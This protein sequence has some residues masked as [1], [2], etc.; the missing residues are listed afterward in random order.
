MGV[1]YCHRQKEIKF[2]I[3]I[4]GKRKIWFTISGL[5]VGL[6]I[7]FL[8]TWGLNFGIDFTG[9]SLL[10][11]N[12]Q[13]EV[14][15]TDDIIGI[16]KETKIIENASAQTV[17]EKGIVLR[18][19]TVSEEDHQKISDA[20]KKSYGDKVQESRFNSIGPTI[21]EGLKKKT[22]Q[23]LVLAIIGIVIYIAWA[24]RHVSKP[25]SSWK[26][27]IIANVAL[28]H[29]VIITLGAF[30]VL[31]K[32]YNMEINS[33]FIAAILTVLGYSVN[34]TIVVFDRIRENLKKYFSKSLEE[35]I[36]KSVSQSI[37]R[38]INTSFTVI[39]VL[40]AILLL[41]GTSVRDFALALIIGVTVGT[42]S[43]IFLASPLLIVMNNWSKGK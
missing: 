33:P 10:E 4:M 36:D 20:L 14:P 42:Y 38:S 19:K 13:E 21:G 27:G 11:L 3:Q 1:A 29:D 28:L 12:F 8:A 23:A 24:F 7:L 18:F 26:Y 25:V 40:F 16:L 34:D 43:S 30:S 35:T 31:G 2:M 41:G 32:L 39:L 6:S 15:K 17:G 9:G 5:M 37:T 22:V